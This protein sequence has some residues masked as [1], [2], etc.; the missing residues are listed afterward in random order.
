MQGELRGRE[1]DSIRF[2]SF[3]L[4]RSYSQMNG[5]PMCVSLSQ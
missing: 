4:G 3:V 5:K 1:K 2:H